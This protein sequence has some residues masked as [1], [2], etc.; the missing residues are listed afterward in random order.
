[1]NCFSRAL[2]IPSAREREKTADKR[3]GAKIGAAE[4][5]RL[6]TEHADKGLTIL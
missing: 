4:G 6:A 5:T 2:T 3:V 1:M